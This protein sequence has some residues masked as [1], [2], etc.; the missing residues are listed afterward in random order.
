MKTKITIFSVTLILLSQAGHAD[1]VMNPS[2]SSSSEGAL[3]TSNLAHTTVG[4]AQ[5]TAITTYI[6]AKMATHPNL[7]NTNIDIST[8]DGKVIL[9]GIVNTNQAQEITELAQSTSGVRSVDTSKLIIG[10]QSNTLYVKPVAASAVPQIDERTNKIEPASTPTLPQTQVNPTDPLFTK[11]SPKVIKNTATNQQLKVKKHLQAHHQTH[12]S[13]AI[14]TTKLA[15]HPHPKT[16]TAYHHLKK[17]LTKALAHL[18]KKHPHKKLI[19]QKKIVKTKLV[20]RKNITPKAPTHHES[21][22]SVAQMTNE[23]L[24]AALATNQPIPEE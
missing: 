10:Q 8:Q 4:I 18:H 12:Q 5:D 23:Y 17:H 6:Y 19:N 2:V 7:A 21:K 22:E 15:H 9:N 3:R 16:R 20:S 13:P 14:K 1:A 11:A 24:K